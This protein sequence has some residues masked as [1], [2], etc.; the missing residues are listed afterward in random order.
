MTDKN[1]ERSPPSGGK[2]RQ[3]ADQNTEEV[4]VVSHRVQLRHPQ[5]F[6]WPTGLTEKRLSKTV[7]GGQFQDAGRHHNAFLN[8]FHGTEI[9]PD[10]LEIID[11]LDPPRRIL[12][13][14]EEEVDMFKAVIVHVIPHQSRKD[15]PP[16]VIMFGSVKG[17]VVVLELFRLK[18]PPMATLALLRRYYPALHRMM[19]HSQIHRFTTSFQALQPFLKEH[20]GSKQ[21]RGLVDLVSSGWPHSA[22][23]HD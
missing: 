16:A 20:V 17:T 21:A 23:R 8:V 15:G 1:P 9:P 19:T 18:A 14:L 22:P 2:T 11:K 5:P 3:M 10:R 7:I 12:T 13:E 4:G 6:K